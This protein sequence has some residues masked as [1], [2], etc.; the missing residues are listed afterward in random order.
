M[1]EARDA[2]T[3][4]LY[5]LD[6]DFTLTRDH[7]RSDDQQRPRLQSRR[8]HDVPRGHAHADR[9]TA[10]TTTPPPERRRIRACWCA[11]RRD[12]DR[13]D[14]AAVDRDGCYWTALYH[15]GK[16]K[17]IAPDG[18]VLAEYPV[19]AMCPT[20]CAFGGRDLTT[21][22]V[23]SARQRRGARRARAA[24]ALRRPL[25]DDGG[26]AG[27]ARA[28]L[29]RLNPLRP[30]RAAAH[31]LRFHRVPSP[32]CAAEPRRVGI[33]RV[34]RD[35][36]RRH[37][38]S[39]LLRAGR[40]P[41]ARG[42]EHEARLRPRRRE[43]QGVRR[44]AGRGRRLEIHRGR[45]HPRTHGR[46]VAFPAA[47]SR[48]PGRRLDHGRAFSR[49]DAA[50]V[51]RPRAPGRAV[52][53]GPGARVGR[54]GVRTR[55]E[56]RAAQQARAADP[57]AGRRRARRQHRPRV[58]E[59][60]VRLEPRHRQG[61]VG[62]VRPHAGDRHARRRAS[63]LVAPILRDTRSTTR[64]STSSS[65]PPTRRPASSICTRSSRAVRRRS[66][67]GA[68]DS[69]SRAPITRRPRKPRPSPRSFARTGFRA[70]C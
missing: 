54:T 70:T 10:T 17:R 18:R 55:R 57:L 6:P 42:T 14:G 16:L 4:A 35:L 62:R 29:R 43:D 11:S 7:I 22:Y 37:P 41:A 69:G 1:N 63:G 30:D 12:G 65:L 61:R 34:A 21:L 23:T 68:W 47:P 25:R 64:R 48:R 51:V 60:A 31:D 40:V 46:A 38:R 36:D 9:S 8:P 2:A 56:I 67:C 13:P 52:D 39:V 59:R 27:P 53:R 58:Q 5:R 26:R 44:R 50:A 24:A 66:R 32:R 28:S 49:L 20:M 33:G 15:G 19:P 3:A 45:H